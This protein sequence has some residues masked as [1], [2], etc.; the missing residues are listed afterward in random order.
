MHRRRLFRFPAFA[1][2]LLLALCSSA[3]ARRP[4]IVN[5]PDNKIADEVLTNL[6]A[7]PLGQTMPRLH[8]KV[9][10]LDDIMPNAFSNFQGQVYITSGIFPA[11]YQDQGVWAAVIGHE[12]GHVLLHNPKSLPAFKARLRQD[13]LAAV[14]ST[15]VPSDWPGLHLGEGISVLKL[16]REEELQADFIGMMLMTEAGYQPGYAVL[17]DQRLRYGL[18]DT[19]GIVAAF[20]HHPRLETRE[21][22]A[23]EF[24]NAAMSIFQMRWPDVAKSPGGNLPPYGQIGAWTLEQTGGRLIFHVPFQV[25]NAEN[26][27]VRIAAIFLD[28][29]QRVPPVDSQYRASDGSLVLN[30]FTPGTVNKAGDVTLQVPVQQLATHDHHVIAVVFLMAGNRAIDLSK[31]GLDLPAK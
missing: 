8:Y 25:H 30:A 18:G 17:L 20:S 13:Y 28:K 4:D 23:Q 29:N 2:A 12:L 3:F 6:L 7:S 21:A 19:P 22:H 11:L 24:Y 27:R 10:L 14:K 26:M 1:L 5:T 9:T 15:H 16:S 31:R